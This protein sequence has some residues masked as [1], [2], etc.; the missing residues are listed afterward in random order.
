MSALFSTQPQAS[1]WQ[2][3]GTCGSPSLAVQPSCPAYTP[4]LS[5]Q[6][7]CPA[8]T[9][10]LHAQP[11]QLQ[12]GSCGRI[13]QTLGHPP[14]DPAS[15][16]HL[17]SSANASTCMAHVEFHGTLLN[18]SHI[19]HT[20][21]QDIRTLNSCTLC[22]TFAHV[23]AATQ[24]APVAP[25]RPLNLWPTNAIHSHAPVMLLGPTKRVNDVVPTRSVA[26]WAKGGRMACPWAAFGSHTKLGAAVSSAEVLRTTAQSAA[27]S[28]LSP[29]RCNPHPA[30]AD[31]IAPRPRT[32]SALRT[33][34]PR[35]QP[36]RAFG[37]A[38]GSHH[39]APHT[40]HD[41]HGQP[42][43][44][45]RPTPPL[46]LPP[47]ACA[48]TD[49]RRAHA[50]RDS[51]HDGDAGGVHGDGVGGASEPRGALS[52]RV[53][54]RRG[55]AAVGAVAASALLPDLTTPALTPLRNRDSSSAAQLGWAAPEPPGPTAR[56]AAA[57]AEMPAG[58]G[59]TAGGLNAPIIPALSPREYLDRISVARGPAWSELSGWMAQSKYKE[60]AEAL[61]LAPFDDV[62]QSAFYLPWAILRVD[63]D[64]AVQ[65]WL[66]C[67]GLVAICPVLLGQPRLAV[68][69]S[70]TPG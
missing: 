37:R 22:S 38:A 60:T 13:M 20:I 7:S 15:C 52:R 3:A 9:P 4:S 49:P 54:L 40:T 55:A 39:R 45:T 14:F 10:S 29:S 67:L 48:S 5:A 42:R 12:C 30:S 32:A 2:Q 27:F 46:P 33:R 68:L 34:Q 36:M 58:A 59:G 8:L 18:V 17:P 53:L 35:M 21:R 16:A 6:A 57:A 70:G 56:G 51:P 31:P 50:R 65:V 69:L 25:A 66:R 41:H 63:E 64:R 24:S 61:V 28:S 62:A 11:S 19:A 43:A 1:I 47:C 44:S 26:L 23:G